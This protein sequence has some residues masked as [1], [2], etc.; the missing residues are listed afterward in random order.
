MIPR[1]VSMESAAVAP[2]ER[3]AYSVERGDRPQRPFAWVNPVIEFAHL[4]VGG[5]RVS[6]HHL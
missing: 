1:L 3:W 5:Y 4:G 2:P 6:T